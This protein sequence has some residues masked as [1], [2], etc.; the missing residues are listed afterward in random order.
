MWVQLKPEDKSA[1]GFDIHLEPEFRSLGIGRHIMNL[2]G[3]KLKDM[4]IKTV[5]IC[6]FEHNEIAR[7]LY[8]SLGFKIV[9]F[10]EQRR[11]FTL[12]ISL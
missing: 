10:N 4:G 1:F 9:K 2:C 6:V 8:D 12:E 5:G 11:Q 7:K 3:K